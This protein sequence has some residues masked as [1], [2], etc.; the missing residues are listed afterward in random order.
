MFRGPVQSTGSS[1]QQ[2]TQ[3]VAAERRNRS[4]WSM[5]QCAS[6]VRVM[7]SPQRRRRRRRGVENP[8]KE[9]FCYKSLLSCTFLPSCIREIGREGV[10]RCSI[11]V[12][13]DWYHKPPL[14]DTEC[15]PSSS[16]LNRSC[17]VA[18]LQVDS[19]PFITAVTSVTHAN[20]RARGCC[21]IYHVS[22]T[23][24]KALGAR[25][26]CTL[27]LSKSSCLCVLQQLNA[28]YHRARPRTAAQGGRTSQEVRGELRCL[29]S[30]CT[31]GGG[32]MLLAGS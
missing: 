14:S 25:M 21:L 8:S 30:P 1:L 20:S 4:C 7:R 26:M 12:Q 17:Q 23:R 18:H 10:T 27:Q 2:R 3:Q 31:A 28:A 24:T 22:C 6:D 32:L 11:G 19:T 15:T 13:N 29:T 5:R 9:S 16:S